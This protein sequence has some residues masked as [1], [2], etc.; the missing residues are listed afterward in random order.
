MRRTL[1]L[2]LAIPVALS[3]QSPLHLGDRVRVIQSRLDSRYWPE[4]VV[5]GR[6]GDSATVERPSVYCDEEVETRTWPTSRLLVRTEG[7][8]MIP[9]GIMTALVG[10]AVTGILVQEV[11]AHRAPSQRIPNKRAAI[12]GA[13]VV[14]PFGL[15]DGI[16]SHEIEW[17]PV[18]EQTATT[19]HMHRLPD[20]PRQTGALP[21]TPRR[22]GP[23]GFGR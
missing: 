19:R 6:A 23:G 13:V 15:R 20:F 11:N 5:I 7:R 9:E 16:R 2:L 4:G 3:A 12:I 1:F 18:V 17:T 21:C 22:T 14:L 10:G 8:R